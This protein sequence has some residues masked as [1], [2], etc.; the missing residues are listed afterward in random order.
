[1]TITQ[2]KSRVNKTLSRI[3]KNRKSLKINPDCSSSNRELNEDFIELERLFHEDFIF[4][5][6]Y[7]LDSKDLFHK[8]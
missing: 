7:R 1:M 6:D 2:W 3:M 8:F 4:F 5:C